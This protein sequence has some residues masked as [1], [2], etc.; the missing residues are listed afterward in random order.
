MSCGLAPHIG[1]VL[2]V[3]IC[4]TLAGDRAFELRWLSVDLVT[5]GS[6]CSAS[7]MDVRLTLWTVLR[8]YFAITYVFWLRLSLFKVSRQALLSASWYRAVLYQVTAWMFW[9][10]AAELQ[11]LWTAFSWNGK[12][13]C[14]VMAKW[15]IGICV[16]PS[17]KTHV[18]SW[19][20][21]EEIEVNLGQNKIYTMSYNKILWAMPDW[22]RFSIL[23][24]GRKIFI[25]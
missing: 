4:I 7:C 21:S 12:T 23:R 17:G 6:C 2:S 25:H 1:Q 18:T 13:K 10:V 8:F 5:L 11:M 24:P 14:M 22:I 19:T 20:L 15:S 16:Q 9:E 3:Y